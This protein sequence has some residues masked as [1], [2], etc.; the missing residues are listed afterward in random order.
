[1]SQEKPYAP[2]GKKVKKAAEEG[3]LPKS[4]H[5]SWAIGFITL[6]A[7]LETLVPAQPL[8]QLEKS[9]YS[10]TPLDMAVNSLTNGI[11][12]LFEILGLCAILS[13]IVSLV[14]TRGALANKMIGFKA[15]S[16]NPFTGAMKICSELKSLPKFLFGMPVLIFLVVLLAFFFSLQRAAALFSGN[17]I[18]WK[19][20]RELIFG[21]LWIVAGFMLLFGIAEFLL[22]CKKFSRDYGMT[23]EEL[24]EEYK[25]EYGDP[26]LKAER[27]SAYEEL[28]LH[29]LEKRIKNSRVIVVAPRKSRRGLA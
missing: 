28:M 7:L 26:H 19:T 17:D 11:F 10:G 4:R 13:A 20:S 6:I 27:K 18:I 23:F 8:I 15:E 14:Q 12:L 21:P 3:K 2:S 22:T 9:N 29:D 24:K 16:L 25:D 1:M 5:L